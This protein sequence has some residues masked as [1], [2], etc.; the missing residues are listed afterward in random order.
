MA[1]QSAECIAVLTVS[2]RFVLSGEQLEIAPCSHVAGRTLDRFRE[3]CD[4]GGGVAQ[5][6]RRDACVKQQFG[7]LCVDAQPGNEGIESRRLP[8][9]RDQQQTAVVVCGCGGG[10]GED[11]GGGGG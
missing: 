10:V 6:C 7:V 4:C 3:E 1:Q 5:L 8:P 11:G 2:D 9:Q